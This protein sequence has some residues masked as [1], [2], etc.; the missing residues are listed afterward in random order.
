M[1]RGV[2]IMAAGAAAIVGASAMAD[3]QARK[4]APTAKPAAVR[5]WAQI[6]SITPEGGF[7]MGNPNARVKLVEYGSLTC[8]TCAKFSTDAKAPL[9]GHVRTGKVS[10]EFRN[11]VLN[12]LDLT[13]ALLA[14]CGGPSRFFPM[15]ERLYA[16]QP[17]WV[18]RVTG[19]SEAQRQ[20]IQKLPSDQQIARVAEYGGLTGMAAAVGVPPRQT[21]ACLSDRAGV[22]RLVQMRQAGDAAG[23]HGT[24]SFFING[25]AVDAHGWAELLPAIRNAGG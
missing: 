25:A 1:M 13:A 11:Y 15:I 23:V 18:G 6:V 19:L 12:S 8:P 21:K 14:R 4:A 10:F 5:D 22:D 9:A 20:E 7:R 24:P 2:W 3:A 17:Q 16:T